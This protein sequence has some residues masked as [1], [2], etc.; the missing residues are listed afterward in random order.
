MIPTLDK[1]RQE[2]QRFR[3]VVYYT[4][5]KPTWTAGDPASTSSQT[6]R[7]LGVPK[8][9]TWALESELASS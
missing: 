2:D 6:T 4:S 8:P 3:V 1:W 5:S 7:K 9:L